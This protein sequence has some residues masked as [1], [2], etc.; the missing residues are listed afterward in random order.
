[1]NGA[2]LATRFVGGALTQG[3]EEEG[4]HSGMILYVATLLYNALAFIKVTSK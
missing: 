2:S 1:M 3:V 4:L